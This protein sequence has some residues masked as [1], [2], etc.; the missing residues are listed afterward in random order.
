MCVCLY[1]YLVPFWSCGYRW[2]RLTYLRCSRK[3]HNSIWTYHGD[4]TTFRLAA[5]VLYLQRASP[6]S[7]YVCPFSFA[8]AS[9]RK[10]RRRY[11]GQERKEQN[12]RSCL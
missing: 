1:V 9:A 10:R 5:A 8:S 11:T 3:C 6:V 7:I 4:D 2:D 12:E